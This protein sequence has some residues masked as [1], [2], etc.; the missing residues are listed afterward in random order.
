MSTL[1]IFQKYAKL[2]SQF[3]LT[4]NSTYAY[5]S[6]GV[7]PIDVIH[8]NRMGLNDK[9]SY[10]DYSEKILNLDKMPWYFTPEL[11]TLI[12][13]KSNTYIYNHT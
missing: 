2:L 4:C 5:L 8:L 11:K 3:N 13:T 9:L 10:K 1:K 7:Y 6:D 12:L